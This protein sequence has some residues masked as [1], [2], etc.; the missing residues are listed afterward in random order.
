M[1]LKTLKKAKKERVNV[2]ACACACVCEREKERGGMGAI[3]FN[4]TD[5]NKLLL[6]RQLRR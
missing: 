3:N 5:K 2:R 1:S 6:V 4:V